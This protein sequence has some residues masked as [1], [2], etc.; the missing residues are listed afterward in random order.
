MDSSS[1]NDSK[2][3]AKKPSTAIIDNQVDANN[4]NK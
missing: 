1:S 4:S 3:T 2:V